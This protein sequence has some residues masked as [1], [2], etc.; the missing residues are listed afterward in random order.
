[1]ATLTRKIQASIISIIDWFYAPFNKY[2]S[3]ET[4]R[5]AVTGGANTVLDIFLYFIFYN[6]IISKQVVDLG[7]IAIS[8]H[9]AAFLMVFPI[10]F[11]T[12]FILAKYIT[13]TQS[14]I[15]GRIQLV[16]YA[17]SVAGSILLNYILL[18]LFVEVAGLYATLSKI[19]TTCVVVV[20]SFIIQKYFTFQT[21]K[22][23]FIN[24]KG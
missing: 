18:K 4:F 17:V 14:E 5:Y 16:R 23:V 12:G 13:F 10:T 2:L 15:R 11:S 3:E 7:F 8:P 21:G 20:Y 1:M 22:K 6:F 9:I 19:L 24:T